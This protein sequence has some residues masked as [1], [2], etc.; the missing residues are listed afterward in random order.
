MKRR[1][2]TELIPGV[3][4]S[5]LPKRKE[6]L[7]IRP[8][9]VI[10]LTDRDRPVVAAAAESVGA[11]YI[12]LPIGYDQRDISEAVSVALTAARPLLIHCFHGRDRA[13]R[14]A[15]QLL[16]AQPGAIILHDVGR[17]LN[18]AIRVAASVGAREISLHRCRPDKG[19]EYDEIKGFA[20]K[21]L[22]DFEL[23]A[24]NTDLGTVWLET[25]G[26]KTIDQIDWLKVRRI[27]IGGET[28]GL[29]KSGINPDHVV[30]LP[31]IGGLCLTVEHALIAG[32]TAWGG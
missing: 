19:R 2:P 24:P 11:H 27:V 9:T 1:E 12:K 22:E 18:R 29:P 4:L 28:N 26:T 14:V 31:Q 7:A 16:R 17:N 3:W 8:A 10:D 15:R 5:G 21:H 13:P 23:T 25:W 32:L 6:I 20:L 30:R